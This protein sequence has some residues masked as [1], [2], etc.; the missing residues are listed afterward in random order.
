MSKAFSIAKA[1]SNPDNVAKLRKHGVIYVD[2]G[3]IALNKGPDL[4][5]QGTRNVAKKAGLIQICSRP[6]LHFQKSG[7]IQVVIDGKA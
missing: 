2:R 1:L 6:I 3:F 5:T 7:T 4:V